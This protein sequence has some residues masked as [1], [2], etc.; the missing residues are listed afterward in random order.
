MIFGA[1]VDG[2]IG[3]KC[4]ADCKSLAPDV[5]WFS[6][7]HH[8]YAVKNLSYFNWGSWG[9]S[10]LDAP[11]VNWDPDHTET[12][13]YRWRTATWKSSIPVTTR[14]LDDASG[15]VAPIMFRLAAESLHAGQ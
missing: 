12:G 11:T 10:G 2:Y 6:R 14:S 5:A 4:F 3:P 13:H 1:V 7:A 8:I 9:Y 15:R